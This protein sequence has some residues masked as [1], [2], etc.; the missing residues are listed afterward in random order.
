MLGLKLN[1]VSKRGQWFVDMSIAWSKQPNAIRE[2]LNMF[3]GFAGHQSS[4][5]NPV[6]VTHYKRPHDAQN[7]ME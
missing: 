3:S 5:N 6:G 7:D 2:S 4:L 1:H